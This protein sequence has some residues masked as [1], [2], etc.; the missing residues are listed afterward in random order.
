MIARKVICFPFPSK[1]DFLVDFIR[2]HARDGPFLDMSANLVKSSKALIDGLLLG[3]SLNRKGNLAPTDNRTR[4]DIERRV[5]T[6]AEFI[7]KRVKLHFEIGILS[8]S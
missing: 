2:G 8:N 3:R 7:A 4:E 5:G 6:H 1:P